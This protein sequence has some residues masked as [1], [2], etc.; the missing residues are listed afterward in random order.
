[1]QTTA[2]ARPHAWGNARPRHKLQEEAELFAD[3]AHSI[4][5]C[6]AKEG[7]QRAERRSWSLFLRRLGKAVAGVATLTSTP[8]PEH[9]WRASGKSLPKLTRKPSHLSGKLLE[10]RKLWQ[11]SRVAC[12]DEVLP[13]A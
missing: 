7:K 10:V 2:S 8:S 5:I 11:S 9:H 3:A 12:C 4:H 6:R 13:D 1:M